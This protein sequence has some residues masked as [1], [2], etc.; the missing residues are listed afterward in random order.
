MNNVLT[1][2]MLLAT[3]LNARAIQM[4]ALDTPHGLSDS[5]RIAW[6]RSTWSEY[7]ESAITESLLTVQRL[8]ELNPPEPAAPPPSPAG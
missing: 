3:A 8:R 7:L 5:D 6:K 4:Q 1:L 2:E